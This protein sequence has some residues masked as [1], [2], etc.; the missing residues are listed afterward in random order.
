MKVEKKKKEHKLKEVFHANQGRIE[1]KFVKL[2]QDGRKTDKY[3]N[4]YD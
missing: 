4:K 1:Y 2:G 3:T